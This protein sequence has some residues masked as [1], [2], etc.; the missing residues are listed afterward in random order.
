MNCRRCSFM[1]NNLRMCEFENLKINKELHIVNP[2]KIF[3]RTAAAA[4]AFSNFQIN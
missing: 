3:K 2:C 4:F 1:G